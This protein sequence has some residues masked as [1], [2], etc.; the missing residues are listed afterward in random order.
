LVSA[1]ADSRRAGTA[2]DDHAYPNSLSARA[3]SLIDVFLQHIESKAG[4]DAAASNQHG[5]GPHFG[6][7]V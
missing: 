1:I 4:A 3:L 5:E 7:A 6:G 2:D